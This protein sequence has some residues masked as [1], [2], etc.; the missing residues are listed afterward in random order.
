[1]ERDVERHLQDISPSAAMVRSVREQLVPPLPIFTASK[2][3]ISS[4]ILSS[5]LMLV[6]IAIHFDRPTQVRE[7]ELDHLPLAVFF[8]INLSH[9][10]SVGYLV[11]TDYR[12][13]INLT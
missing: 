12:H 8:D 11:I 4:Q 6:L 5:C 13:Q 9:H 1:M 2:R 3:H 10:E 7:R